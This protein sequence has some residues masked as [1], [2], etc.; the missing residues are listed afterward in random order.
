M[1]RQAD[2]DTIVKQQS[3]ASPQ[4]WR[5]LFS[6]FT[7]IRRCSVLNLPLFALVAGLTTTVLH[8]QPVSGQEQPSEQG[9]VFATVNGEPIQLS[10]YQTMLHLSARQ[11][12]YH[13]K[14][15]EE[16]LRAFRKEVGDRL[17]D[18]SVLHQE[19][20]RRGIEPDAE[21]VNAELNKNV[22]R[23][24]VQKGWDQARDHLIPVMRAGLERS[25]RIRQ[26]QDLFRREAPIP[27]D[28]EVRAYYEANIDKF[29]SPPQTRLSM[30]MLK[31][32]AWGDTEIWSTRRDEL[33]KIKHQI[34]EGMEFKE[35]ARRY[36]DDSSAS[37]GGDLGYLHEGMLGAQ[38]EA[39]ISAMKVGE[40]S[41]PVT[42]LEGV[43]LFL[44]ND[45]S[46]EQV[47]PLEKVHKR[48][49]ELLMREKQEAAV[50]EGVRRLRDSADVRYAD[51]EYYELRQEVNGRS[52]IKKS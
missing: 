16:E 51:P 28:D 29:T 46:G 31:V 27:D 2:K 26:L 45:R 34:S 11:H 50:V 37:S 25:D 18:E 39:V 43:A 6:R 15:P 52:E 20:L 9:Q 22:K 13:G 7:K 32:P 19:A 4:G 36:S 47:N 35:A 1:Y 42:L 48:A 8:T 10:T 33:S 30:I 5:L 41:E 38:A 21:R 24:A 44:L 40:I 3:T 17:I 49:V 14:P 12:F 23:L